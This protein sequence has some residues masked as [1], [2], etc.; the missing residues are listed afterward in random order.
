MKNIIFMTLLGTGLAFTGTGLNCSEVKEMKL[1]EI[2][3]CVEQTDE[4]LNQNYKDLMKSYTEA[5][6]RIEALKKTQRAW[7]KFRESEC[8]YRLTG[9]VSFARE[10]AYKSCVV[11]LTVQR[12]EVLEEY[13]K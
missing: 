7:L 11:E 9:S 13:L 4:V 10:E 5:P 8:E 3:H 12:N 1:N 2:D 6:H